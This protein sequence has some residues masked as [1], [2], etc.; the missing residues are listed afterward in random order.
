M[1]ATNS[2][3]YY[4]GVSP[5]ESI[6]QLV[7][8]DKPKWNGTA[9]ELI[10]ALGLDIKPNALAMRLN[11]RTSKLANDYGISYESSRS[12]A[13]RAITLTLIKTA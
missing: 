2:M 1:A 3:P 5:K 7:T 9:T 6:S 4:A 12:H 11:V 8:P 10:T 13:G